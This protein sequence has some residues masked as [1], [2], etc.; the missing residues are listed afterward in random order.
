VLPLGTYMLYVHVDPARVADAEQP[1]QLSLALG[2]PA[3]ELTDSPAAPADGVEV[4]AEVV[5]PPPTPDD[6]SLAA[7]V[8]P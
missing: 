3:P 5:A 1:Y 4:P 6:P 2:P 7:L 8:T